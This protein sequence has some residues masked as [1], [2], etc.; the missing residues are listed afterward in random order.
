[1]SLH[2]YLL[3]LGFEAV[4]E[5]K[6][7]TMY[8]RNAGPRGLLVHVVCREMPLFGTGVELRTQWT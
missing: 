4:R 7:G 3:A 5:G 2:Q 6:S 1:M 8:R